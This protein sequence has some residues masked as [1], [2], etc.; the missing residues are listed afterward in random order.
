M[1]AAEEKKTALIVVR[2]YPAPTEKGVESSC[3]AA[4]T[5]TGEWLRLFPVRY[6]Y[7]PH[8][9]QFAKYQWVEF[10][11]TKA[12]DPRPES[13]TPKHKSF[14]IL[15]TPLSTANAWRARK[16]VISPLAAHSLC[17]LQEACD[18]D[19]HPTLG[20]FRP[21]VIDEFRIIESPEPNWTPKQLDLLRQQH[22]FEESPKQELEK[23]P[24]HFYYYFKCDDAACKGHHLSCT[25][26]EMGESY[27]KWKREYG[28]QWKQKFR[29]TYETD[30]ITKYDTHFFVGTLHHYPGTW[31]IIGLF[32]PPRS[33]QSE[34]F[35]G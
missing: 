27:R 12:S 34:M 21:R 2:T 22:L 17:S 20:F 5:D 19:G 28:A 13:Y 15:T 3:T 24:F 1:Q 7:L 32:Y 16:E 31:I 6:R 9:Q 14:N 23:I 26:W 4:I 35:V 33:P 10:A 8:D 25:D 29:Q 11:A 30:M 18:R